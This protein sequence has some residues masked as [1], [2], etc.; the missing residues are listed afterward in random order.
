[1]QIQPAAISKIMGRYKISG[2]RL[3]AVSLFQSYVLSE[4]V[5]AAQGEDWRIAIFAFFQTSY[6]SEVV[7][8]SQETVQTAGLGGT[9][10]R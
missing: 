4:G 3:L 2:Q 7:E 5:L 8:G 6:L 10:G 1:M 9:A